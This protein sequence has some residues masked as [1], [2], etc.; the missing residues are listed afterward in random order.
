MSA[1][2]CRYTGGKIIKSYDETDWF[3]H[4]YLTEDN[5]AVT[6]V[7]EGIVLNLEMAKEK[8]R[9]RKDF[10]TRFLPSLYIDN[11]GLIGTDNDVF[12]YFWSPEYN[13]HYGYASILVDNSFGNS[14]MDRFISFLETASY[15]LKFRVFADTQKA[16]EKAKNWLFDKVDQKLIE[17]CLSFYDHVQKNDKDLKFL[18]GIMQ[19]RKQKEIAKVSGLSIDTIKRIPREEFFLKT[20]GTR[21]L[22]KLSKHISLIRELDAL[23]DQ[24]TEKYPEKSIFSFFWGK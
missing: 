21:N 2:I 1:D 6:K 17:R 12:N 15:K 13:A 18:A 5:I 19:Q 7:R 23:L 8:T 22:H 4:F 11:R 16:E 14:V 3:S 24:E 20:F 9:L 10:N